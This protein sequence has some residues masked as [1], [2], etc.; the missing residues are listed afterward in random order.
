MLGE[1]ERSTRVFRAVALKIAG[2]LGMLLTCDQQTPVD[3]GE[4]SH[5]A[6]L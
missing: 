4:A 2:Y 1:L 5:W 3:D 6:Q